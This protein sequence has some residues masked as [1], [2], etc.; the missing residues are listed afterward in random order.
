LSLSSSS[1]VP[2]ANARGRS[3]VSRS[4]SPRTA[5]RTTRTKTTHCKSCARDSKGRIARSATAKRDFQ[6]AHPCPATG[7]T[8]GACK[9]YVIDHVLPLKRGGADA[10]GNMQ[11]QTVQ[12][13]KAKDRVE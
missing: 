12:A 11:W 10:P 5:T 13:P 9:G 3:S 1:L 6:K 2:F 8:S 4:S 7:K